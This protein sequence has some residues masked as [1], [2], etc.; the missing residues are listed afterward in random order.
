M[1]LSTTD[2]KRPS[3]E[4]RFLLVNMFVNTLVMKKAMNIVEEDLSRKCGEEEV[5]DN[6]FD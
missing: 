1:V 2:E 5:K 6:G 3:K 4:R